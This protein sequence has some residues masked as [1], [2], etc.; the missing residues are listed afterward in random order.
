MDYGL[1]ANDYATFNLNNKLYGYGVGFRY[2]I[3]NI[4]GADMCVGLNPYD[5][6]KTFH[7]IA[8]FKNF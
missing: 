3:L 1:G 7:F 8:N 2:N 5:G 6:S 4:G